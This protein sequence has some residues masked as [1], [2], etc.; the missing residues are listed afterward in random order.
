MNVAFL[1]GSG[2]SCPAGMP[3]TANLTQ[4]ILAGDGYARHSDGS[5]FKGPALYAHFGDPDLYVPHISRFLRWLACTVSPY[6]ERRLGRSVS[7]EDLYYV[8]GQIHDE[9]VGNLD[10]PLVFDTQHDI[11]PKLC[12]CRDRIG[13]GIHSS[14]KINV[15]TLE[16]LNYIASVVARELADPPGPADY[17]GFFHEA[18]RASPS[19]QLSVFTLNH[20]LLLEQFLISRGVAVIDGFDSVV[21]SVRYWNPRLFSEHVTGCVIIKLHGSIQ[22]FRF[23]PDGGD[24]RDERIGCPQKSDIQHT[25][26]PGRKMQRALDLRPLMLIGTF[27]KIPE[28]TGSIFS[29]LFAEFRRRLAESDTLVV[30]GYGFGDK[31]INEQVIEWLYG[32]SDRR[33]L[34]IHPEPD[35]LCAAARGAVR[36]KWKTWLSQ[37]MILLYKSRVEHIT[38][39]EVA[40][41]IAAS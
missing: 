31:G 40:A 19:G 15:V 1:L 36:D 10:N 38:W 25:K 5:Y 28:Y 37:G 4:T 32:R 18:L 16:I 14:P 3:T 23:R 24:W 6:Y 13:R 33:L 41:E 7:Y 2:A 21:D 29:D 34:L 30:C 9:E 39:Q 27:N 35:E 20:D 8:I 17:L 11:R 22:W 12:E 26:G